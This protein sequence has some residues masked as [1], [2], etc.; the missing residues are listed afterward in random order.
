MDKAKISN[1]SL[2]Y[3]KSIHEIK[4][5]E[6]ILHPVYRQDG[7]MIVNE[8]SLLT[9]YTISQIQTHL[10]A[11][12]PCI[13]LK[14]NASVKDFE[15]AS[16]YTDAAFI[17]NIRKIIDI[18]QITSISKLYLNAFINYRSDEEIRSRLVDILVDMPFWNFFEDRFESQ[19]LR[20]RARAAKKRIIEVFN[21][22]YMVELADTLY[23]Y[24]P[25]IMIQ[26]MNALCMSLFIGL[27]VE[28]TVEEL[29]ELSIAAF[30]CNAGF[31]KIDK[32]IYRDFLHGKFFQSI[33]NEHINYT[34]DFLESSPYSKNKNILFGVLEHHE[35]YNG[36]GLPSGKKGRELSL[37]GRILIIAQDYDDLVSGCYGKVAVNTF[38]AQTYLFRNEEKRY[39]PDI[40]KLFI[41]R[42]NIFKI[43]GQF[44]NLHNDKGII[45]GF[46]NFIEEPLKPIVQFEDGRVIDYYVD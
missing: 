26:G 45:I 39:D 11:G 21:E 5:G 2:Y 8:M 27:T 29:L 10:D 46:R 15:D 35:Y 19:H 36:N 3:I 9:D 7:L 37:F 34:L 31:T 1:N 6:V 18:S 22:S 20:N 16:A 28:L 43:G 13:V 38:Q 17:S 14:E 32:K 41:Y 25:Q 40:I 24:D 44:I 33:V 30:L 4:K 42:T 12:A 23:E